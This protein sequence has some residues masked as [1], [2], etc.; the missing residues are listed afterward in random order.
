NEHARRFPPTASNTMRLMLR[1]LSESRGLWLFWLAPLVTMLLTVPVLF[2]TP[3]LERQVIDGV[4]LSNRM[5]LLVP[6][7]VLV[8]VLWFAGATLQLV[9]AVLR[10]YLGEQL[11]R[12]VQRQL[13]AHC[14]QL[15][16]AFSNRQHSGR[17]MALFSSDVPAV[18]G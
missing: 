13:F 14:E 4:L 1:F 12:R 18:A 11:G 17:T 3:L 7:V 10:T 8:A 6:T 16:L 9:G 2:A 5:D 15:A